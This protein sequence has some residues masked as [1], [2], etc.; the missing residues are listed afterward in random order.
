MEET[1]TV[2]EVMDRTALVSTQAK[3]VCHSCSARGICHMSGQK[4]TMEVE[5]WNRLGAAVGD[6][7]QIR[8]SGR[9]ALTAAFLLYLVPLLGFLVGVW[10][11]QKVTGNQVW[12]VVIGLGFL[13]A[14]YG[15]IRILDRRIDRSARMR[16]EITRIVVRGPS[17]P[18]TDSAA[19]AGGRG[20]SG[21][22]PS[23][24]ESG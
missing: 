7:V 22:Q 17:R 19:E 24:N 9:S 23:R 4:E 11:G 5:A 6:R 14:V 15:G 18:E 21:G 16:P 2:I 3:G 1:G 8:I 12:A 20:P 13:A 10:I